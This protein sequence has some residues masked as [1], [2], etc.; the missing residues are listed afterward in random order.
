MLFGQL[1]FKGLSK[2]WRGPSSRRDTHSALESTTAKHYGHSILGAEQRHHQHEEAMTDSDKIEDVRKFLRNIS[3][4]LTAA[5]LL[6]AL[7]AVN[8][9]EFENNNYVRQK[10]TEIHILITLIITIVLFEPVTFL[11]DR[12]EKYKLAPYILALIV[13]LLMFGYQVGYYS[14][15]PSEHSI[16]LRNYDYEK[17]TSPEREIYSKAHDRLLDCILRSRF[18]KFDLMLAQKLKD[19]ETANWGDEVIFI[20]NICD[21]LERSRVDA[22]EKFDSARKAAREKLD[23]LYS[24]AEKAPFED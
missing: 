16:A 21:P 11:R 14:I 17:E 18:L 6:G 7:S 20:E 1:V 8:L 22:L 19:D 10:L 13:L 4:G 24:K 3:F 9:A 23:D 12:Y 15:I 2:S 5:L